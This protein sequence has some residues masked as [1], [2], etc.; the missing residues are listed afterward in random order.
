MGSSGLAGRAIAVVFAVLSLSSGAVVAA[1]QPVEARWEKRDAYQPSQITFRV[2]GAVI[3]PVVTAVRAVS[4]DEV[5]SVRQTVTDGG[6]EVRIEL[7]NEGVV[8][9]KTKLSADKPKVLVSTAAIFSGSVTVHVVGV[10]R[11][12]CTGRSGPSLQSPEALASGVN[13]AD[14]CA[15]LQDRSTQHGLVIRATQE[16]APAQFSIQADE[17]GVRLTVARGGADITITIEAF[18]GDALI[19]YEDSA[20]AGAAEVVAGATG[21]VSPATATKP[22]DEVPGR[23]RWFES[24]QRLFKPLLADQREAQ[25]RVG[26]G[27][28]EGSEKFLDAGIG[29][30]LVIA[31][32]VLGPQEEVSISARGLLTARLLTCEESFPLLNADYIAGVAAGY[33]RGADT[34]ELF[35]FHES[36]H[37]GDE[38]FEE[39]LKERIDFSMEALRALW[40]RQVWGVRLYAGPTFIMRGFPQDIEHRLTL[41]GGAEYDF[42]MFGQP[43]YAAVDLQSREQNG[44]SVNVAGQ[45]GW[46]LDGDGQSRNRPRLFVEVFHGHSNM[47]QFWEETETSVLLGFGANF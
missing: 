16:G 11:V 1:D 46:Y 45:L 22:A 25:I 39:G 35:L 3:G 40:S 32:R 28:G 34:F 38:T 47:G 18:T 36:S 29:G 7:A 15:V 19:A 17:D 12:I 24:E 33:R 5:V 21:Q 20:P 26:L 13:V 6:S 14:G 8:Y 44:W 10:D 43:L 30:D 41:Q 42:Q 9:V 4:Q 2:D 23:W 31:S 27:Y 37:L